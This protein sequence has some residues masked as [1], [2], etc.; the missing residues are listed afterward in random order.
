MR[1]RILILAALTLGGCHSAEKAA[2]YAA[3][4]DLRDP[5]SA[6]FR[7]VRANHE[8]V[9]CG[10]VSGNNRR[11]FETEFRKFIYYSHT[12]NSLQEPANVSV[13]YDKA[14]LI[15]RTSHAPKAC[16]IEKTLANANQQHE[17][18]VTR[19]DIDCE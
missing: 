1:S 18:F 9:I 10:E 15:C 6:Q 8:G 17:H 3:T 14:E 19:Y 7:G 5:A 11:G 13:T 2:E 16:A 12:G 4:R